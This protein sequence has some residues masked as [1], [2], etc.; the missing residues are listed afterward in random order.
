MDIVFDIATE[1]LSIDITNI[2]PWGANLRAV[3]NRYGHTINLKG[4]TMRLTINADGSQ[5]VDMQ[6]PPPGVSYSKT[7]QDLLASGRAIWR[8]D[9]QIEV[10]ACC[11]TSSGLDLA[12][13]A[14][15]IVPRPTKPYPSWIWRD[16]RWQA[17]APYP[18]NGDNYYWDEDIMDWIKSFNRTM[19]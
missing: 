18:D 3:L 9:Q 5:I 4:V 16:S 2:S 13:N 8:P 15:F 11:K 17:P 12:T 19:I 1:K 10:N 6:M 7:N 14:S